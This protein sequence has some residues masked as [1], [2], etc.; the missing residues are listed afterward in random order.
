MLLKHMI[1]ALVIGYAHGTACHPTMKGRNL[2]LCEALDEKGAA[3]GEVTL[4]VD[5]LG[6][7]PGNRVLI[8]ADGGGAARMVG[9]PRT[10]LRNF[11]M[12]IVDPKGGQA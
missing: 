8:S 5:R 12:G 4:A 2:L 9:T 10:P 3:T 7:G 11:V 1:S 6:A